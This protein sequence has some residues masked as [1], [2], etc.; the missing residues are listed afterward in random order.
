MSCLVEVLNWGVHRE[1]NLPD[2][3]HRVQEGPEIDCPEMYR[4]L[5]VF[6]GYEAEVESQLY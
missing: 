1:V 5:G 3:E 4:A 2:E 6:A